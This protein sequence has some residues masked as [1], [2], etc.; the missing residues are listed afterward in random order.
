MQRNYHNEMLKILLA[1]E[2]RASPHRLFLHSC[3]G[4]CSTVALS[5][6]RPH[7]A[8]GLFYYNPNIDS[9]EEYSRR[10]DS[11]RRVVWGFSQGPLSS[12][13]GRGPIEYIESGY[14]PD[15]FKP[16]A[17]GLAS[18]PEGG[19]RCRL[20][21]RLRL[22]RSALEAA[23]RG[24]G[25]LA[26]TLSLGPTKDA[27]MINELGEEAAGK[28]GLSWLPADFKK[29]GGH[30]LAIRLSKE[31]ALYRQDYCGCTYSKGKARN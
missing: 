9:Q 14:R 7:F 6:L 28:N 26:S 16:V 31:L 3:C 13:Q 22:E 29:G 27:A 11:Q 18:E 8:L 1:L 12:G 10:A 25:F 24:Y 20:C 5:A 17:E 21:V 30:Q 2:G 4:P 19:R 15:E 23:A